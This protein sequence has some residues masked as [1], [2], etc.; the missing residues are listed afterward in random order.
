MSYLAGSVLS[1]AVLSWVTLPD[2]STAVTGYRPTRPKYGSHQE[3]L[4]SNL[5][6]L[7]FP[8]LRIIL[9]LENMATGDISLMFL[10]W[11]QGI[12]FQE[13]KK[14]CQFLNNLDDFS[15]AMKMYTYAQQP[16]SQG[17]L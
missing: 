3:Q 9:C 12:T 13:F 17:M 6:K 7:W 4:H 15:I 10:F 11:F 16:V 14:F 1:F 2:F 8:R 5:P